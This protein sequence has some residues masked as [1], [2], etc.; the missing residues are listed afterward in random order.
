MQNENPTSPKSRVAF[1]LLLAIGITLLFFWVIRG[2]VLALAV[3]A[4]LAGLAHPIHRRLVKLVRGRTSLAATLT[5]LLAVVVVI[6]PA[7][8]F[9]GVLLRDA[10]E[11]SDRVGLWVAEHAQKPGSLQQAVEEDSTL[12][13]LLPYQDQIVQKAGVLAGKVTSFVA[14]AVVT[15][16]TGAAQFFLMLFVT[17]YAMF[18]FLKDGRALLDGVFGYTPLSDGDKQ[19]LVTTFSSVARATLKGTLVIGIVQGALAGAAFAVAGIDGALFW[20]AVMAVL[21]IVPGVGTG[22]VWVPAVI[23]LAMIDR[24]GAAVGLAVWC[25]VVVGT[26]DNVLRPILVGKDTKMSDLMVMLT[27]LGGLMLFGAVGIVLGPVIGALLT[28]VWALW[29]KAAAE[30]RPAGGATNAGGGD[31]RQ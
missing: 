13:R 22:L 17:V 3:A 10:V 14:Q 24:V 8:L 31:D 12:R 4:I 15:G 21:S 26:A 11:I 16:A 9:L 20:G 5:V 2:F 27:T 28:T 19:R 18:Y 1:L 30:A 29:G 23:Y 6:V 7:L 25:A